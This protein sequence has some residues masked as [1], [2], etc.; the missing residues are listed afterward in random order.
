MSLKDLQEAGVL[1]P[2]EEWGVHD[3]HT[4]VNKPLLVAALAVGLGAVVMMYLGAGGTLTFVGTAVFVG[5]MVWITHISIKAV[6]VQAAQ[7]AEEHEHFLDEHPDV[8]DRLPDEVAA[9]E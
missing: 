8:E 9:D 2:K 6:D 3:L 1:L 7:F 5:F 4:S